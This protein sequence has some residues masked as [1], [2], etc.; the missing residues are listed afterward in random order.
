MEETVEETVDIIINAFKENPKITQK[1]L[2]AITGLTRRGI[3]WNIDKLKKEGRIRRVGP[4]KGGHWEIIEDD[5]EYI[6]D[7]DEYIKDDE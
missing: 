6:K 3:E 7:D 5:D 2:S 4:R 1:E